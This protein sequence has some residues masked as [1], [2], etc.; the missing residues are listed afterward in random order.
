M[1]TLKHGLKL[2][3]LPVAQ[4]NR[5]CPQQV[6]GVNSITSQQYNESACNTFDIVGRFSGCPS[7]KFAEISQ[8]AY[9]DS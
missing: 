5:N 1:K 6:N 8:V 2:D 4:Q 7:I 3:S 9:R